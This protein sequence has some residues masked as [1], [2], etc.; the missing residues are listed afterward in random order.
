MRC[1]C[2]YLL[3]RKTIA[4]MV[5][6]VSSS[7]YH[8]RT[9]D[10]SNQLRISTC[11]DEFRTPNE[12]IQRAKISSNIRS[13]SLHWRRLELERW[14]KTSMSVFCILFVSF[15]LSIAQGAPYLGDTCVA[16]VLEPLMP[17]WSSIRVFYGCAMASADL[18]TT[19]LKACATVKV[20]YDR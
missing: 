13:A 17:Y 12:C 15:V 16:E 14:S 3:R 4:T 5:E 9:T 18:G 6:Y 7:W 19:A 11:E 10:L 8:A 20:M 2:C 1:L